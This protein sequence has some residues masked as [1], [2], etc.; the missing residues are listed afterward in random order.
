MYQ[1]ALYR[2]KTDVEASKEQLSSNQRI[3]KIIHEKAC[4]R[5]NYNQ[6]SFRYTYVPGTMSHRPPS[7]IGLYVL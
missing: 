5:I 6:W 4:G 1:K 7:Q 2:H 3:Y